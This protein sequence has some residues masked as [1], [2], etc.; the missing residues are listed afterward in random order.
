MEKR[1]QRTKDT[2]QRV[3]PS[4]GKEREEKDGSRSNPTSVIGALAAIEV[5]FF[6]AQGGL[7]AFISRVG[8]I[9]QTGTVFKRAA[10]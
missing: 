7:L 5:T 3:R 9:Y 1:P 2:L 4:M 10:L 6:L 8:R